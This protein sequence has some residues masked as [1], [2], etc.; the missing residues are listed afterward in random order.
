[1][2]DASELRSPRSRDEL[3]AWVEQHGI[4]KL[5]VGGCDTLGQY[6][7][8]RIPFRMLEGALDHGV[9]FSDVFFALDH[10]EDL[11]EPPGGADYPHYFPRK[12]QGFP[13][14][15]LH[16]DP[17]SVRLMPWHAKT[18]A[19]TGDY[20]LPSG[21]PV[22]VA[23]RW[24]LSQVIDRARSLG[25]TA[26]IGI[27]FEFYFL[28]EDFASLEAKAYQ[29]LEALSGRAY[30]YSVY[31]QGLDEALVG[32]IQEFLDGA[33]IPVEAY[34]PE[35][36][37][38][39]FEVNLR[40]ADALESAD[41][42]FFYK[43][44]IK[45]IA[46]L[47][48]MM[49]SFI[50][51]LRSEWAGSSC[52]LHLSL[53][54]ENGKNVFYDSERPHGVS[55]VAQRFAAGMLATLREFTPFFCPT[56]N[57]YKRLVPYSW[58]ATNVSWGADNRSTALRAICEGA[59]SSRIE[60]RMPGA[61]LNPYIGIAAALAGGLHGIEQ[62]LEPPELFAG[63]AYADDVS[64]DAVP[65]TLDEAIALLE[66]SKVAIDYLG[67]DFCNHYAISKRFEIAQQRLAVTDWEVRR[68]IEMA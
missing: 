49:A 58:G 42:A 39:Q 9:A 61:D 28:K 64:F 20:L 52:H 6:K 37:P 60:H 16:V 2:S 45:E 26:K 53:W 67:E 29:N 5:V 63:D 33:S 21:A 66:D 12:E 19:I 38:G 68:F 46:G 40:Y 57:S 55:T 13:D 43:N 8:K 32:E 35:T 48:G 34:N 41:R 17:R 25:Y 31:R 10:A 3:L 7:G 11:I 15:F 18:A 62:E 59:E 65:G 4:T 27:E 30:T 56:V 44:G 36:G 23:P 54:D 22:P 47:R 1:M 50:A 51:K 24:V 14:I